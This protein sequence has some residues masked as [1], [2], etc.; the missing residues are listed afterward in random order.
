MLIV[1][2]SLTLW[3]LP[4]L[5]AQGA[6]SSEGACGQPMISSRIVG[7][8]DASEGAWPWQVSI[9]CGGQSVCGGSLINEQWVVTAAHCF[10][11]SQC[12]PYE[13]KLGA[14]KLMDISDNTVISSVKEVILNPAYQGYEGSSGDIALLQLDTPVTYSAYILPVCV[15]KSSVRF[16]AGTRCWVTGWGEVKSGEALQSPQILQELEVPLI[17]RDT[18]NNLFSINPPVDLEPDPVKPD[19]FCAGYPEGGKD[20]C[21]GDSGGPL[22]CPCGNAWILAGVVSWGEGCAQPNFPGV[23]TSVACYADWIYEKIPTLTFVECGS[24]GTNKKRV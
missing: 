5:M 4:L 11:E 13:V 6:A 8:Q 3:L 18:C 22:V 16:P 9:M 1:P 23:Y 15:P 21:Q 17:D 24:D 12:D 19:M 2:P 14:Y 10:T 20:A 7:G